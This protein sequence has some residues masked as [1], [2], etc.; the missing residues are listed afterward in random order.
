MAAQKKVSIQ[1]LALEWINTRSEKD[2]NALYKRLR[3]GLWT[4]IGGFESDFEER[5]SLI[6]LVFAKAI[7]SI[8]QYSPDK[9]NFSTWIYRIAFNEALTEKARKGRC[10][11]LDALQDEGFPVKEEGH[12]AE[13]D[14]FDLEF[15]RDKENVFSELYDK[16][17]KAFAEC[18]DKTI[19]EAFVK[20]HFEKKPY[21]QIGKEL[22]ICTNTAKQKIFKGKKIVKEALMKSD[23]NLVE[24][25]RE[26]FQ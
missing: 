15:G 21:E 11:S 19:S 3:P 25:Y 23:A 8:D 6:N 4:Y 17:V 16:T 9:G 1:E 22:G 18:K 20:W 2:F 12:E 7:K 26:N 14:K 10:T 5:D 24:C 13:V